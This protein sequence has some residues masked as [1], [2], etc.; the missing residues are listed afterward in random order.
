MLR[1]SDIV[2]S[3]VDNLI[4]MCIVH[5]YPFHST[6]ENWLLSLNRA[7]TKPPPHIMFLMHIYMTPG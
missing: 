6:E 4:F 3:T 5:K 1:G 7:M 2:Y